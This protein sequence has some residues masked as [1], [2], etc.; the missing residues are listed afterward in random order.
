MSIPV[1]VKFLSPS[2]LDTWRTCQA[3]WMYRYVLKVPDSAGPAAVVGSFVHSVLEE[4][5][6]LPPGDRVV[7]NARRLARTEWNKLERDREFRAMELTDAEARQMRQDAWELI[8][9]YFAMEDPNEVRVVSTER[10]VRA[11][12]GGVPFYGIVDRIDRHPG[13]SGYLS[14]VDYKT[15][16]PPSKAE[17]TQI[18]LYAEAI[19]AVDGRRPRRLR[20]LYLKADQPHERGVAGWMTKTVVR[21]LQL[22]WAEIEVACSEEWFPATVNNL[23]AWCP[24]VHLCDEGRTEMMKKWEAGKLTP[25]RHPAVERLGLVKEAV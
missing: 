18:M 6:Q 14:V 15:G 23:C 11:E 19:A 20:Y 5:L 12:V 22:A 24:A 21:N 13:R 9:R 7:E 16:R 4:L 1:P 8:E 3:K 2:S 17:Y 25:G 10:R